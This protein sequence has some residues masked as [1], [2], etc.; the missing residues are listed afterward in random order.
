LSKKTEFVTFI[1]IKIMKSFLLSYR[2]FDDKS[3][4]LPRFTFH[5]NPAVMSGDDT[6]AD[7]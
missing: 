1:N 7:T 5:V 2:Q 3:G 6:M 4:S